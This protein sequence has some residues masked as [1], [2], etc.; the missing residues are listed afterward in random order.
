[1]GENSILVLGDY[2]R[3]DI[4]IVLFLCTI[5]RAGASALAEIFGRNQ[6]PTKLD[7]CRIDNFVLANGLCENSRLKSWR[8]NISSNVDVGKREVLAIAGALR[9]NKGLSTWI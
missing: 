4:E 7:L 2:S 5:T 6:G 1:M 8:P 3:S 9:E